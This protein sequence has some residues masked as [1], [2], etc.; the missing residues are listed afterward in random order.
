VHETAQTLFPASSLTQTDP[1]LQ[2]FEAQG[3]AHVFVLLLLF[4]VSPLG[5]QP[6][7]IPPTT[8]ATAVGNPFVRA[9]I[10]RPHPLAL[11]AR[12]VLK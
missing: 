8:S 7:R 11:A 4:G 1:A 12:A 9:F 2:Q 5:P 10:L 3:T 6:A